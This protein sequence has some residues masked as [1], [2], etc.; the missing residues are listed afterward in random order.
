MKS[1]TK[2]TVLVEPKKW[3]GMIKNFS[4]TLHQTCAPNFQIRLSQDFPKLIFEHQ[5]RNS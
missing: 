4:G 2:M 5:L 1:R 3:R